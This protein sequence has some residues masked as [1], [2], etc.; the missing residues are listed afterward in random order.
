[1]TIHTVM[2][3]AGCVRPKLGPDFGSDDWIRSEYVKYVLNE[4]FGDAILP[5]LSPFDMSIHYAH[6]V[7]RRRR[8]LCRP[9]APTSRG[10]A[11]WV[12]QDDVRRAP[13]AGGCED[14]F[15]YVE[16]LI[17]WT[18]ARRGC[19]RLYAARS[20]NDIGMTMYRMRQRC[21]IMLVLLP[22]SSVP[23]ASD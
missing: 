21:W 23:V 8:A 14:L 9:P 2:N 11:C 6:L 20:R 3:A 16:R 1:M 4:N 17:W 15:Y 18:R 5:L 12:S 22:P 19:R 10:G 7:M 13:F